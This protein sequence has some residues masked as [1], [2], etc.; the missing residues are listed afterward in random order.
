MLKIQMKHKP[1]WM[2]KNGRATADVVTNHIEFLSLPTGLAY[3][4]PTRWSLKVVGSSISLL[5]VQ[6]STYHWL[7]IEAI[8]IISVDEDLVLKTGWYLFHIYETIWKIGE[9][10]HEEHY[11]EPDC[12]LIYL[13]WY[14]SFKTDT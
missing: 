5:M 13:D 8:L 2:Q 10:G 14:R 6:D 12:S 9:V 7:C 3:K 1:A 11:H 4:R